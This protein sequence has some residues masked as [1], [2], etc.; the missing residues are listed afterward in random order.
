MIFKNFFGFSTSY[1]DLDSVDKLNKSHLLKNGLIH[2][3]FY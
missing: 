2:L 1:G 3:G